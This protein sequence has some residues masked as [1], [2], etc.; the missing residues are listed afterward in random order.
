[1]KI[2]IREGSSAKNFEALY[3]LID[4]YPD[5]C[6]FCSDDL[7]PDDLLRGHI[8]LLVKCSIAKG[9][10]LWNVLQVA[11]LNPKKHY[12][13]EHG[14]LRV[15]DS[16]DFIEV[17]NLIDFNII[18]TYIRGSVVSTNQTSMV[19]FQKE[20]AINFFE[21]DFISI[22]SLKMRNHN[23]KIRVIKAI[24][25]ELITKEVWEEPTIQDDLIISDT[26]RDILKIVV[27]NRYQKDSR[28]SIDF[29]EGFGIQKGAIASTIAHDS[30]NIIAVGVDDRSIAK[31][32]NLL[33]EQKGGISAV[34]E[35]QSELL[36]LEIAGLMSQKEG[37]EI[38]KAYQ[39][40]DNIIKTQMNSTLKAPYM[41]LS[42]MALL[43]IPEI[44]MS[45]KGLFSARGFRF[46]S[47]YV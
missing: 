23:S 18:K 41:T 4:K 34:Y 42:F 31:A 32:I 8:N 25:G 16:A 6:M 19:E 38:A 7:H 45:D 30:H 11:S 1:M 29:I 46:V 22:E 2:Q 9:L 37:V 28:P 20:R 26:S 27:L 13:L 47:R 21:A 3:P 39:K 12:N 14:L 35:D 36:P 5:S 15:G 33:I 44:K 10:N 24:D 40:L 43:V 17:D